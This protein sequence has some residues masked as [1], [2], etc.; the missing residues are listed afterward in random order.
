MKDTQRNFVSMSMANINNDDDDNN[1]ET[2]SPAY[3]IALIKSKQWPFC[4]CVEVVYWLI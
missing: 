1:V 2:H 3:I 4:V